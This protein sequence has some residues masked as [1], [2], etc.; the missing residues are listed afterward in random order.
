MGRF[1]R[2]LLSLDGYLPLYE[3]SSSPDNSQSKD[4]P[5]GLTA[6]GCLKVRRVWEALGGSEE[7]R[8]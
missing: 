5:G 8:F 7:H 2:K 3:I 6:A 4:F 1:V